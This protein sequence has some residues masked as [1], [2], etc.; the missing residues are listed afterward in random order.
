MKQRGLSIGM[1]ALVSLSP[2][3]AQVYTVGSTQCRADPVSGVVNCTGQQT[4]YSQK[5]FHEVLL[6]AAAEASS[7][8]RNRAIAEA[9]HAQAEL[10]RIQAREAGKAAAMDRVVS[11]IGSAEKVEGEARETLLRIA[12]EE[13]FRLYPA[14]K[15]P[16]GSTVLVPMSS[17]GWDRMACDR[18]KLQL[19]QVQVFDG[20]YSEAGSISGVRLLVVNMT[21]DE[22]HDTMEVIFIDESGRRLWSEEVAFAWTLNFERQTTKLADRMAKKIKSRI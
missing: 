10:L 11:L 21:P 4:P 22:N 19:G 12:S 13:L 14:R 1:L 18:M 2:L 3:G 16:A 7:I 17:D 8:Q 9:M 6:E 5:P 20:T 15:Y